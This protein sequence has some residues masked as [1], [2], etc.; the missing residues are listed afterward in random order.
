MIYVEINGRLGNNMFEIAAAKSLTDD[1]TLWCKGDWQLNCIEMYR[2]TLFKD[3]PIVK[4]LPDNI[5]IYEE[6]EFTFHPIPYKENQDLLIKGYFQ[7]YKYLNREKV[8]QLY[9][10]PISVKLDIEKRFG[11]ILSQHT[12]VSINVRRGDYL[13]LPHRHPFVGKR[14]L[15]RAM[16]WFGDKVH[17]I[18]SSDDI[19]WCKTHFKQ[20]DNVHYLTNSYPLLD[21]YIQTACHHNIISNSSFSWWGAYLNNHPQKIV[22]APHRWFG[23]STNINTQDLLPPEWMIEHCVYEP[24]V[25]FKALPLHAKYLLK[26]VLRNND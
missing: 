26:K 5:K 23:M 19:E 2:E 15:E 25:F 16:L 14:F 6:P 17:Y 9:P 10:C 22:I 24:K 18:I 8:L 4:F 3:Y 7:S 21:L 13:K 11:N 20:F 1:V 12:V